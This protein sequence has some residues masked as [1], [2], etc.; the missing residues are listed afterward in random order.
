MAHNTDCIFTNQRNLLCNV[1]KHLYFVCLFTISIYLFGLFISV[2]IMNQLPITYHSQVFCLIFRYFL[3]GVL[4]YQVYIFIKT[5]NMLFFHKLQ[6][7]STNALKVEEP[8]CLFLSLVPFECL[9]CNRFTQQHILVDVDTNLSIN[10]I[11]V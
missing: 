4:T 10:M 3:S 5:E 9:Q 2:N 7:I 8:Q 6:L 1:L 11:I